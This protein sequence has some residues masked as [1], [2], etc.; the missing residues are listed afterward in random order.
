VRQERL[1]LEQ[2]SRARKPL[3]RC[4]DGEGWDFYGHFNS[5]FGGLFSLAMDLQAFL[6]NLVCLPLMRGEQS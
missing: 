1:Q 3:A 5:G 6:G 4:S 2:Y